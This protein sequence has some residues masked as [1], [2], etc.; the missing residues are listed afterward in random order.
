MESFVMEPRGIE[1]VF[2]YGLQDLAE[3]PDGRADPSIP[4]AARTIRVAIAPETV[5]DY[6]AG[7]LTAVELRSAAVIVDVAGTRADA[8]D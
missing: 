5:E 1:L 6:A 7:A 3:L 8:D 4:F 2:E